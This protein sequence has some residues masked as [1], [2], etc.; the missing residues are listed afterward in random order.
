MVAGAGLLLVT[1]TLKVWPVVQRTKMP[2]PDAPT[3]V[4]LYS[5][6]AFTTAIANNTNIA[7][8]GT[9]DPTLGTNYA[10]GLLLVTCT[11]KVWPVVQRT[12]MPF[13]DAPTRVAFK[14][15]TQGIAYTLYSDAAFTTA[16]ANN[17][18]IAASGT[19]DPTL[20]QAASAQQPDHPSYPTAGVS[21]SPPR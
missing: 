7:A 5:D 21:S 4:T 20:G 2:F 8:S 11:L 6:A 16:I 3:R 15:S 17:T 12:K 9:T 14:V 1:C 18:N 10:T 13:P 19:T